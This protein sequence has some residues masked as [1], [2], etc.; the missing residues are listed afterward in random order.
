MTTRRCN[1][2]LAAAVLILG[3]GSVAAPHTV[4]GQDTPVRV[5]ET[6]IRVID[7]VSR[8][9][10]AFPEI[11]ALGR[12]ED[13]LGRYLGSADGM[14]EVA[15]PD[16]TQAIRVTALGFSP[17][18]VLP[19][20]SEEIEIALE[21]RPI[22]LDSL[23]VT[24]AANGRAEFSARRDRG[25]GVFLDPVDIQ[26]KIKYRV[27]DAFYEVPKLRMSYG[28]SRDGFPNLIS[29][30]GAGCLVYR[31][32]NMVLRDLPTGS[33]AWSTW[34]LSMVTTE[35]VMAMEIYRYFG[36]V[37]PELRHQAGIYDAPCGLIV[38]WTTVAW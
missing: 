13:V 38:I 37:P 3:L 8:L 16:G 10:V 20:A 12:G 4:R 36:E 31:L 21:T 17:R 2:A 25:S 23:V 30:L 32:D 22:P 26:T 7:A 14:A 6:R 9:A 11:E 5:Q 27:T 15:L 19:P 35:N 18:V 34:P 28:N 29:Q 33:R 1:T 24:A